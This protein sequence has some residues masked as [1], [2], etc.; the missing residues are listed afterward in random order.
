MVPTVQ[1]GGTNVGA[2]VGV[3][4]ATLV[5]RV[6]SARGVVPQQADGSPAA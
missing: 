5:H 6:N 4:L 1:S 3:V 2:P